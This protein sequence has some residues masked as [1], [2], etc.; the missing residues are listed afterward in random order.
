MGKLVVEFGGKLK[1]GEIIRAVLDAVQRNALS[2][3]DKSI[4]HFS[5]E[6][7][8]DFK[9]K[10]IGKH[11]RIS[12]IM[13]IRRL[14]RQNA[15]ETLPGK[16][17]R[18]ALTPKGAELLKRYNLISPNEGISPWDKKWRIVIFDIPESKRGR[19]IQ[20]TRY[21]RQ[22]GFQRLRKS[23]YIHKHNL[24]S[25]VNAITR[26]LKLDEHITVIEAVAIIDET[27]FHKMH[28]SKG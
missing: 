23:A 5:P 25:R 11:R 17:L 22:L 4:S 6:S 19:R 26:L 16:K 1:H 3:E 10:G 2:F 28:D 8:A 12:L 7:L 27:R 14:I 15:I 18:L 9:V 21:L 20:F 24:A 13:A